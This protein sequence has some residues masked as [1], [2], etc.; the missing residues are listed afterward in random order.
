MNI[1]ICTE[2]GVSTPYINIEK[3]LKFYTEEVRG[4]GVM[5]RLAG[6]RQRLLFHI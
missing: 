3:S 6:D 2:Y 4:F 1:C 5:I